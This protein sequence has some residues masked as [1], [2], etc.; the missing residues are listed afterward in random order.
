MASQSVQKV[1]EEWEAAHLLSL[2]ADVD[3]GVTRGQ[4]VQ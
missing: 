3:L 4:R 1:C 2:H